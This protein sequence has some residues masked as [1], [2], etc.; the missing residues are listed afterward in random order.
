[1]KSVVPL[2]GLG[3]RKEIELCA[4]LTRRTRFDR[5]KTQNRLFAWLKILMLQLACVLHL[6][7]SMSDVLCPGSNP[8]LIQR[9]AVGNLITVRF[10]VFSL[11]PAQHH[12]LKSRRRVKDVCSISR[13]GREG[14]VRSR[15]KIQQHTALC[16]LRSDPVLAVPGTRAFQVIDDRLEPGKVLLHRERDRIMDHLKHA[17]L[18]EFPRRIAGDALRTSTKLFRL[19]LTYGLTSASELVKNGL[20][21]D[22][23]AP[24]NRVDDLWDS[25]SQEVG[26]LDIIEFDDIGQVVKEGLIFFGKIVNWP[27]A[28]SILY[29]LQMVR[30][31]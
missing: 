10:R 26:S 22:T 6:E 27:T 25:F 16:Y 2:W 3:G 23:A 30:R 17:L 20:I 13:R 8:F 15:P 9:E 14:G 4:R 31:R 19:S 21:N 11:L 7:L 1:M 24:A 5:N 29:P 12:G 18:T 28:T